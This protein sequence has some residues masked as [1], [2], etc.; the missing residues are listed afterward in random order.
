M[1][2]NEVLAEI[3]LGLL[4]TIGQDGNAEVTSM[5]DSATDD[6]ERKLGPLSRNPVEVRSSAV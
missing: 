6:D 2:A 4:W 1:D 5:H 3:T